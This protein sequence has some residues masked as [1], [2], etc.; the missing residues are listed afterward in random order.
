MYVPSK[1]ILDKYANILVNFA[2]RWWKWINPWDVVFVQIPECA[3]PFYI[4]L[5]TSILKAW[6][7]PI[8]QYIPDGVAKS[9]YENASDEQLSF[10]PEEYQKWKIESITHFLRVI[11]D[12]DLHELDGINPSKIMKKIKSHKKYRDL[13]DKKENEWKLSRTACMYWTQAMANEA[14][15]SLEEYR[16]QIISA[17]FL[18]E[19]DPIKKR[20][21][22]FL[23]T[24]RVKDKLNKLKL[25]YV[26]VIWKD[27][28]LKIKIWS[29]RLRASWSGSN[30]PS[31][32]IFTSPDCRDVNWWMRC[33][34]PLYRYWS[35]VEWIR[36]EFK[37]WKLIKALA[38]KNNH[39]L[40]EMIKIEWMDHIWEFSLTDARISK[41]THFMAETLFDENVW[42]EFWNTHIALWRWFEECCI[43]ERSQLNN[44]K[45]K[46][47]IWLNYSDEHVDVI[48][49]ENR[50]VI[51]I[52]RD[53]SEIL[54]YENGN[55]L[56]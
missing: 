33:N 9:F 40:Q 21:E 7:H 16:N 39:I 8:M 38:D 56:I 14:W 48:S 11:A 28:N 41:I 53:W 34:Q 12:S 54:V 43:H 26:H 37:D 24:S 18:D 15:L 2:L 20:K 22:V 19:L 36:L 46:K 49:T 1:E 51:W 17:C 47:S 4:P 5:Q 25:E 31:F 6:W 32:E 45:F 30:I 10:A 55:F 52:L 23:E 13:R 29:D 44:L 27:E 35:L 42:W 3:K 50:K